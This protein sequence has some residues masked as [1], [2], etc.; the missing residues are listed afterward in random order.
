M[1]TTLSSV[2]SDNM[3]DSLN[4]DIGTSHKLILFTSGDVEVA[5][6][7]YSSA[8]GVVGVGNPIDLTYAH[9]N[10]TDDLTAAG[11]TV[12]YAVIQTSGSTERVRFSDPTNDIG[13]S[14]LSITGGDT[15]D[16]NVNIVVQMPNH[17]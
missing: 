1:A 14:S 7:T 6:M 2:S 17:T 8:S 9:G 4:T 10:Y 13:L 15:V 3:M 11:G 12:S 5:T 16:V